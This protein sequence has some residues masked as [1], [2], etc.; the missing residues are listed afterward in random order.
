MDAEEHRVS[1][2]RVKELEVGSRMGSWL[3]VGARSPY[4]GLGC[5]VGVEP[6]CDKGK[7]VAGSCSSPELPHG[8]GSP[9]PSFTHWCA[10]RPEQI[11]VAA[12][13]LG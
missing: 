1:M 7:M 4:L 11:F 2:Q 6:F 5:S 12:F 8:V 3:G 9:G 13:P 10:P